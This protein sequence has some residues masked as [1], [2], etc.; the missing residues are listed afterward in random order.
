MSSLIKNVDS[1]LGADLYE[2]TYLILSASSRVNLIIA[3]ADITSVAKVR[4]R[5]KVGTLKELHLSLAELFERVQVISIQQNISG[6]RGWVA[7][8]V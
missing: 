5:G 7:L 1:L 4:T 3:Q 6:Q 8:A 2:L